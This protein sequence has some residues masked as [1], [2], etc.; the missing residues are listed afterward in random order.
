[1]GEP[2]RPNAIDRERAIDR[3]REIIQAIRD[4]DDPPYPRITPGM[5]VNRIDAKDENEQLDRLAWLLASTLDMVNTALQRACDIADDLNGDNG[6]TEELER[7]R[8]E[9]A[10][11]RA[12]GVPVYFCACCGKREAVCMGRY[13]AMTAVEPACDECCGHGNEDGSCHE[14]DHPALT[15]VLEVE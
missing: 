4:D 14:I 15:L 5:V 3:A 13:E 8:K 10:E 7:R 6:D 11:L 1:M 12:I 9:I 2:A